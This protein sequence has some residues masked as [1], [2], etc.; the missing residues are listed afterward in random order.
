[1]KT[2]QWLLADHPRGR[3]LRE[4]DF[5]LVEAEISDDPGPGR[6]LLQT[7]WLGFDP[8]QKGWAENV[9]DYVAPMRI[10]DVMRGSGIARVVR[11]RHPRFA[12]GELLVGLTGWTEWLVS[13]GIGFERVHP[14]LPPLAMLSVLGTTGLTAWCGLFKL[15]EPR[16][17][18]T[19]VIS[20]AAGA[21]GSTAGQLAKVAGCRVIGIAGGPEKC[22][23]LVDEAGFDAAIDYKNEEVRPRLK[24]LAPRGIDVVFDNV[25]GQILDDMLA[26]IATGARVVICGGISRYETGVLPAG[27]QNYFN[28]V[29]RRGTMRGFIV[30]DWASEFPA[31]RQRLADL[32]NAG[33]L[34]WRVDEQ[35]GFENAPRTLMRLF[36]GE[37]RGKQVLKVAD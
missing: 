10:G 5:R 25:G 16:P 14:G 34:R 36:R 31:I 18:D 2:R 26:E 13:D 4:E 28:L 19:V 12:E 22:A 20:G 30:L 6:M 27:P 3:P 33:R 11:S 9:A 35:Q 24:E 7:L 17:G 37:N 1:M 23:W 32:V 21:T 29:F 8:A 15:G